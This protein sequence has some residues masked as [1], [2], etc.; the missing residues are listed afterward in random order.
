MNTRSLALFAGLFLIMLVW[1]AACRPDTAAPAPDD[2]LVV[3][4]LNEPSSLH[5]LL[6][7]DLA[8]QLLLN[9]THQK[10]LNYDFE[11]YK[12]VPVLADSLPLVE[13]LGD[14]SLS[15]TYRIRKEATWAD[16]VP[17]TGYDV[18]FTC[19][20]IAH[21]AIGADH[22]KPYLKSITKVMVDPDQPKRIT[23]ICQ[24]I[25]VRAINTTG[26]EFF[27]LP[28]HHYDP[29]GYLRKIP[30]QYPLQGDSSTMQAF[31]DGFTQ[32]DYARQPEAMLGSGP[33]RISEW[34][35]G[36]RVT[37]SK[38]P[39][40][41][42][43]EVTED[44]SA[45]FEAYPAS[46]THEII[47]DQAAA[48]TAM[49]AGK[50][51]VMRSIRPK[52]FREDLMQNAAFKARFR[53]A[54]PPQFSYSCFGINMRHPLFQDQ[55]TRQALAY[56]TPYDRMRKDLLYGF[57]TAITGPVL[58][59]VEQWYNDT[60][61]PYT[62]QPE[63]AARLL[64]EAGWRDSNGDGIL[65]KMMDGDRVSFSFNF[66]L[67]AGNRE[68]E[69]VALMYQNALAQAGIEMEITPFEWS[70]YLDK[71][72]QHDF[73]MFYVVLSTD[74]G[75]EDFSQLWHTS[76]ADGGSNFVFFGNTYTDSLVTAINTTLA[77]EQRADLVN[78]LQAIIHRQVPYIFL[79][80]PENR[81]AISKAW[82]GGHIS[83]Y[84]PGYW[85]PALRTAKE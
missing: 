35:Y 81:I 75:L 31:A 12:L 55:K 66:M 43:H 57:A 4:E 61:K 13:P 52:D 7:N 54:H 32:L 64:S 82:K 6:A 10:L 16:G 72:M 8:A 49:K 15:I 70:I 69:K 27:I 34:V 77:E 41:W 29:E 2:Q 23:F 14:S 67:N 58:P 60:L 42:G 11:T 40:W 51:D 37:A 80:S 56:L 74:P 73:E 48:I 17:V 18:A 44:T 71:I 20:A 22:L 63:K 50:V 39:N 45:Y 62:Y 46:I 68:R 47:S 59:V 33:Y 5:P 9:Y 78:Q 79:W 21:P 25:H 26:A 53:L 36:Q 24:P 30:Y 65:D 19:K 83:A 1:M 76:S 38:I 3:W 85:A 84:R 28:R